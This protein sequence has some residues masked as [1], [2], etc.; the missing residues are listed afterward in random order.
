MILEPEKIDNEI[1]YEVENKISNYSEM[2]IEQRKFLNG[3]LRTLKPKKIL[4]VGISAGASSSIILNAIKDLADSKLYSIDYNTNWYRDNKKLSGFLV[5]DNFPNLMDKWNLYTGGVSAKFMEEIGGDIDFF[6]LDTM[7]C[8]PGEFL[9]YLMVL[10]FL[11]K[12]A[13]IVIHD[14]ILHTSIFGEFNYKD[15][16][17]NCIL[18]S[19]LKGEKFLLK[20]DNHSY[21]KEKHHIKLIDISGIPNIGA[22]KLDDNIMSYSQDIFMLL[23]LPWYYTPTDDDYLNILNLFIKYYPENLVNMFER[24][25]LFNR[26]I[27]N[28]SNNFNN[29]VTIYDNKNGRLNIMDIIFSIEDNIQYRI[30]RIFGIKIT[31]KKK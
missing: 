3:L 8:N 20:K 5:M 23:T 9:D 21:D 26:N 18:F 19:S 29:N 15:F 24:I 10:P 12:N 25:Y 4:E 13:V 2:S 27:S 31:I 14:L 17:T 1:L 11:K 16:S 6:L 22:I 7:H 28:Q 30:I